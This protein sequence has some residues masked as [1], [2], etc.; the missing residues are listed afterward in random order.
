MEGVGE[1]NFFSGQ[2]GLDRAEDPYLCV[3]DEQNAA[4]G[5]R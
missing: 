2:Q 1:P 4:P 3:F 5:I